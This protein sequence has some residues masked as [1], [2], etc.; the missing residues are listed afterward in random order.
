MESTDTC[1]RRKFPWELH[2][3]FCLVT[4]TVGYGI[5]QQYH[6]S[7]EEYYPYMV[8]GLVACFIGLLR[9]SGVAWWATVI[10]FSL[11]SIMA[12]MESWTKVSR[13]GFRAHPLLL[14]AHAMTALCGTVTGLLI[15]CRVRGAY[16]RPAKPMM[17]ELTAF[18]KLAAVVGPI[19]SIL[20][21]VFSLTLILLFST[22][23]GNSEWY[24]ATS[25]KTITSAEADFRANDR[26]WNRVN[27]Y[28]VGDVAGLYCIVPKEPAGAPMIKL[29]ELSV[30]SA[31]GNPLPGAYPE[32]PAIPSSKGGIWFQALETDRSTVP[33]TP[34]WT[35]K[36]PFNTTQYGFISYPDDYIGG[37][38]YVFIVNENNTI[39]R[40][41]LKD[42]V[43][44][45]DKVPPGRLKLAGF[46]D[47]PS[48]D[49]LKANWS[50]LD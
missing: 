17:E 43:K 18:A 38:K 28:W 45:S 6:W 13:Y 1:P 27:D 19:L 50:K 42:D 22:G 37:G 34:Y 14:H 32:L 44:A 3:I 11:L 39:F 24:R 2:A 16:P 25:L 5:S 8:A 49:E 46:T 12:L 47:W 40:R 29:I 23:R 7:V 33:P 21:A 9:G 20:A 4:L 36:K 26:D 15:R 30:A 35:D 41:E 31:D 10:A 48:D